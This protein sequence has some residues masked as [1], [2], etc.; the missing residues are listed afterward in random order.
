MSEYEEVLHDEEI[1]AVFNGSINQSE[2]SESWISVVNKIK[3]SIYGDDTQFLY[4]AGKSPYILNC[5]EIVKAQDEERWTKVVK[6]IL[7]EKAG[8]K[9]ADRLQLSHEAC[10]LLWDYHILSVDDVGLLY[11]EISPKK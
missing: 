10:I 6:Y 8:M 9:K 3:C 4:D 5:D 7:A 2:N 11:S 1:K